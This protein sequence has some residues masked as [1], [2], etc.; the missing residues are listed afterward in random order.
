MAVLFIGVIVIILMVGKAKRKKR[1]RNTPYFR[2]LPNDGD[3]NVSYVLGSRLS[4][5]EEESLLGARILRLLAM[6]CLE[7]VQ[8]AMDAKEVPL[9]LVREPHSGNAYDEALYTILQ[10][11]AG[12]NGV[13][14]PKEL[15]QFCDQ[16]PGGESLAKLMDSC[17]RSG[18]TVLVRKGCLKGAVC[19]DAG[20]LTTL[21]QKQLDELLGLKRYL[22]DFSLLAEREVKDTIIWQDYMVYAVL[23]GI[24]DQVIEQLKTVYPAQL[25]E[26]ERYARYATYSSRYDWM[27]YSGI[28][29][30]R[31]RQEA[32]R[33]GGSGGRASFGGGGGFSGGGGGGTR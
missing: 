15:E 14:D 32:L 1:E 5:I 2:D 12:E 21:G 7:P 27:L 19:E 6:G 16:Q 25:P 9:R 24:A 22:L 20:D 28:R 33:S 3:L 26:I 11:A 29:R 23:L 30:E 18:M 31:Q 4:Y 10:V 8:T 13:L 17:E